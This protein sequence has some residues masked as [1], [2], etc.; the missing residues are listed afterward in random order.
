MSF[1]NTVCNVC[2][3][4]ALFETDFGLTEVNGTFSPSSLTSSLDATLN[5]EIDEA[6]ELMAIKQ[7]LNPL[8]VVPLTISDLDLFNPLLPDDEA[9]EDFL[10]LDFDSLLT[11]SEHSF[12]NQQLSI[13]PEG[14]FA[15]ASASTPAFDFDAELEK[16]FEESNKNEI[17]PFHAN[18]HAQSQFQ[19]KLGKTTQSKHSHKDALFGT[20]VFQKKQ[21][22][23]AKSIAKGFMITKFPI[24]KPFSPKKP[25]QKRAKPQFS[26]E[27]YNRAAKYWNTIT[28]SK[29]YHETLMKFAQIREQT[30]LVEIPVEQYKKK[31]VAALLPNYVEVSAFQSLQGVDGWY[32]KANTVRDS[33]MLALRWCGQKQNFYN[34]FV[35]RHRVSS[36]GKDVEKQFLCPYCPFSK[37][38]ALD[39]IFHTASTAAYQ[40]HVCKDHG[41][42]TTGY[43]M[44]LPVIG[45]INDEPVAY[46]TECEHAHK[47]VLDTEKDD[48]QN[49]LIA[50]FRHCFVEHNLKRQCRSNDIKYRDEINQRAGR[51]GYLH[52]DAEE[53]KPFLL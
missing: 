30:K 41:V 5:A 35:Y 36:N 45:K 51:E 11:E 16:L 15:P 8:H 42:Y 53:V 34:S 50:H 46:C 52:E 4:D 49:C 17:L 37:D 26:P 10:N 38:M 24:I 23:S 19:R 43:E 31:V 13:S 14:P 28:E 6:F 20:L 1:A 7:D 9:D 44:P 48:L 12:G 39:T 40:H 21:S 32:Y 27:Y 22:S 47:I 33:T 18:V 2:P 25:K 3:S 29:T